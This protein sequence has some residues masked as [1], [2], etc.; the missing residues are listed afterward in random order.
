V[1]ASR[2][3]PLL[4][5]RQH[6][7]PATASRKTPPLPNLEWEHRTSQPP[8]VAPVVRPLD[9]A[10]LQ[11]LLATKSPAV[12]V[13][14][15]ACYYGAYSDKAYVTN[16]LGAQLLFGRSWLDFVSFVSRWLR[17]G[18]RLRGVFRG[19]RRKAPSFQTEGY[20]GF[21]VLGAANVTERGL[22]R[23]E[24]RYVDGRL[25][26]PVGYWRCSAG[27]PADDQWNGPPLP[28]CPLDAHLL[29]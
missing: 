5:P 6:I 16:Q 7:R 28:R 20:L 4:P 27:G 23:T 2:K 13:D 17:V 26:V 8:P 18:G 3:P 24:M 9:F 11:P 22:N 1:L 14:R 21:S 10:S 19:A 15:D 29:L 25:C 12:V